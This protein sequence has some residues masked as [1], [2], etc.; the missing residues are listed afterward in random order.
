MANEERIYTEFENFHDDSI[1]EGYKLGG[2]GCE[3]NVLENDPI[4][5]VVKLEV[6]PGPEVCGPCSLKR[7]CKEK[8]ADSDKV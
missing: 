8:V 1:L 7:F 6:I 4:E 3:S 2:T 5:G